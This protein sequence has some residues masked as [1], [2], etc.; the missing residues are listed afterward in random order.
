MNSKNEIMD[1]KYEA[2]GFGIGFDDIGL[3]Q[4]RRW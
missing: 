3:Q 4:Q 1:R 2:V